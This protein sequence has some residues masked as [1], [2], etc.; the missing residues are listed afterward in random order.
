MKP[1]VFLFSVLDSAHPSANFCWLLFLQE[2]AAFVVRS[3]LM[4]LEHVVSTVIPEIIPGLQQR[5][6][7]KM[8]MRN[9]GH[10]DHHCQLNY[11]FSGELRRM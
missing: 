1:T 5:L 10:L 3:K 8:V 7:D 4:G 2:M 6:Q 11:S 9:Y